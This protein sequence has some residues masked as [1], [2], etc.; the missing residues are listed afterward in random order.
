MDAA[1]RAF[2]LDIMTAQPD[3]TLATLRPDGWPQA[4][5]VSYANDGLV[6]YFGTNRDSQKV[7]NIR[8]CP[9]VSATIDK[10]YEDWNHIQGLSMAASA[11]ILTDR[12]EIDRAIA[13]ITRRFPQAAAWAGELANIVFVKLTPKVISVLDYTKGFGHTELIGL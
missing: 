5:T 13:C 9:R 2:I 10:P 6:I 8:A 7:A 12:N 4:T 1:M 11:E 3:L